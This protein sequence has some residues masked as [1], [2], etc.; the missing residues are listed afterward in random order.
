MRLFLRPHCW[1]L[2]VCRK[3]EKQKE[4]KR[5]EEQKRKIASLS[6][7]PDDEGE[8]EEEEEEEDDELDCELIMHFLECEGRVEIVNCDGPICICVEQTSCQRRRNW[9]KIP[10]W[11]QVSF[12][13]ETER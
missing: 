5:K 11:T 3:L 2:R 13:I 8:E 10:T 6:F 7:N 9:G 4:K 12:L 1:L